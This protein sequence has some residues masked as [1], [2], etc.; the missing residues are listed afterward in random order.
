MKNGT[1]AKLSYVIPCFANSD[2]SSSTSNT[3][4]LWVAS[5]V[6]AI[7]ESKYWDSTAILIVWDDWGGWFDH[8]TPEHP[9]YNPSDPYEYGFRVPMLVVS[10]YVKQAGLVDHTVRNATS[11]LSF[12]E[13]VF[14][15]GSL[16]TLDQYSDDLT[17][18]IFDFRRTPLSYT[19][20]STGSFDPTMCSSI[21]ALEDAPVDD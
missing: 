17:A 7:G 12:I 13:R 20:V 4:P 5:V 10:P 16:N 14:G 1:L 8:Y 9:S 2:H 15:L 18:A 6:N 19:P 11:I 21:H 3:G